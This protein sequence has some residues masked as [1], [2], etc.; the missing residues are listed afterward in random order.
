MMELHKYTPKL[1]FED[2][3]R[4]D[5][6]ISHYEEYIDFD[7]LLERLALDKNDNHHQQQQASGVVQQ[8]QHKITFYFF[9]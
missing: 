6:A 2:G 3:H 4:V 1:N 7:L 8:Q 5:T 9:T